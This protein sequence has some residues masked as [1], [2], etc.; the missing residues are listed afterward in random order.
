M[1]V[2]QDHGH[3]SMILFHTHT[4]K[5]LNIWGT[6]AC[7]ML[8]SGVSTTIQ[9]NDDVHQLRRRQQKEGPPGRMQHDARVRRNAE[10]QTRAFWF[11]CDAI[12]PPQR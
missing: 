11:F 1:R 9:E 4:R 5:L 8:L 3:M 6:M 12:G 2:E 10:V 7:D